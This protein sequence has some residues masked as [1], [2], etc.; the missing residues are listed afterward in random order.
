MIELL[1]ESLRVSLD[2]IKSN[3]LRSFLTTLGIIIGVMTIIIVVSIIDGLEAKVQET[4]SSIGS[5][6]IYVQRRGWVMA[7]RSDWRK[8]R[9][10]YVDMDDYEKLKSMMTTV[11]EVGVS[12]GRMLNVKYKNEQLELISVDGIS[13]NGFDIGN[14]EMD[15][16]VRFSTDDIK[17]RRNVCVIGKDIAENLYGSMNPIGEW[18][19][20]DGRKYLI[21]G[22]LKEKGAIFGQS[23]DEIVLIPYSVMLKYYSGERK[24]ISVQLTSQNP[25]ETIEEA[26]WVMRISHS[27][28]PDEEDDFAINTQDALMKQWQSLTTSIF[29]VM[30]AIGSLSLIVGGIGIMNI[31]LV[32]VSERTREIGIRKSIGAKNKEILLQFLLESITVSV[33]GGMLGIIA[34]LSI[35]YLASNISNLPFGIQI[36]SI[37]TG[38]LFSL[39]VGLFFGI[40]PARKAAKMDPVECLRYE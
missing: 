10:N 25:K 23:Q 40:F 22:V 26:R 15:V 17:Y 4:F 20:V 34:G 11:D 8:T 38:F 5:N 19:T 32:S 18:L 27:L 39:G 24:H 9:D 14:Y 29:M 36:W 3:K 16:G 21:K 35:A 33:V 1:I 13:A 31:M 7:G 2:S 28:R 6:V 12:V 30:I 37:L